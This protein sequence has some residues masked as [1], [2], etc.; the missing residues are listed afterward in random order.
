MAML[1]IKPLYWKLINYAPRFITN[2][3]HFSIIERTQSINS[4][5]KLRDHT[6]R[7]IWIVKQ[8]NVPM[9]LK[10]VNR[11]RSTRLDIQQGIIAEWNKK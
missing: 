10:V 4:V 1:W 5:V 11:G 6:R 2:M 8:A 3:R 7:C 9:L